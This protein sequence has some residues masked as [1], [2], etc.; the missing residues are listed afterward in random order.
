MSVVMLEILNKLAIPR[1]LQFIGDISYTVYL[2]HILVLSA[3]GRL[4]LLT[5]PAPNSLL[6][7][8]LACFTMIA[9]IVGYGWLG[10]RLIEQPILQVSHRLRTRWFENARL[11]SHL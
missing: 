4:W 2:S 10:Y 1:F 7:N 8:M 9:A 3:I 6:D 11:N 5:T